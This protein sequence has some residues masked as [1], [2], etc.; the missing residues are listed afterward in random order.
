MSILVLGGTGF[1]GPRAIRRLVA[2]GEHVVCMDINPG[3]A[4]FATL[5]L[6][7]RAD[8]ISANTRP[9]SR[10]AAAARLS[11]RVKAPTAC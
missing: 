4:S 9:C 6:S 10:E 1:I 11:S 2:R 5:A 8:S 3:A 7:P